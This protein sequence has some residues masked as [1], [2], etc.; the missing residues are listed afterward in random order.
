MPSPADST[1]N[2]HNTSHTHT[3][4][5]H[6]HDATH[7]SSRNML[8][9]PRQGMPPSVDKNKKTKTKTSLLVSQVKPATS[10]ADCN[11][12]AQVATR[13]HAPG[14]S[15]LGG[16]QVDLPHSHRRVGTNETPND[17]QPRTQTHDTQTHTHANEILQ[18]KYFERNT[19]CSQHPTSGATEH[20]LGASQHPMGGAAAAA[21]P[22]RASHPPPSTKPARKIT[23]R[24]Q[25]GLA[26]TPHRL[27]VAV[28][29]SKGTL[30]IP[31]FQLAPDNHRQPMSVR[32]RP[33]RS[34][35]ILL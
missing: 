14:P 28:P 11:L 26:P 30:E 9:H 32:E 20:R 25:A 35:H 13:R 27:H 22:R 7:A 21:D 15:H 29:R 33:P 34:H 1:T 24:S 4:G 3:A 10:C 18:T 2:S 5:C 19:S 16:S 17:R 8:A 23:G 6:S 12:I 31:G